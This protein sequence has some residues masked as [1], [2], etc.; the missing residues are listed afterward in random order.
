MVRSGV[1]ASF[2]RS[3]SPSSVAKVVT[4]DVQTWPVVVLLSEITVAVRPS[5]S[6]TWS[7]AI[8]YADAA[9]ITLIE[10]TAE[11][12][13]ELPVLCELLTSVLAVVC[14]AWRSC[15]IRT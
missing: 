4:T 11:S 7:C 15:A 5:A 6:S 1:D 13:P 10:R 3:S 12:L 2:A 14:G 9:R 8:R